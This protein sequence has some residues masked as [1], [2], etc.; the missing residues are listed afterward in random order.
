MYGSQVTIGSEANNRKQVRICV[1]DY[2]SFSSSLKE[3]FPVE[4]EA[5]DKYIELLK[6]LVENQLICFLWFS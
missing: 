6:V 4:K 5:I 2:T 1:G 3:Q